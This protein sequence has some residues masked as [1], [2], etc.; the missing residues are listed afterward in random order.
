MKI[1]LVA[2]ARPNFMKVAP[3]VRAI[4]RHNRCLSPGTQRM[5]Y[6]LIHTG[7]H[8]DFEMSA[9]FFRDLDLPTPDIHLNVGSG[10][11]A[12]QTGKIMIEFEKVCL[13]E[14][15]DLVV[16]VGD[17]NS[18]VA[19]ALTAAKLFI[20]V[21]HIEAGLRSF[22]RTM[23]EEINRVLTDQVSDFLFTTFL[24]ANR[25]LIR[26]GIPKKKIFFVG[27]V[28]IDT[29]ISH[30]QYAERSD[31]LEK[32]NLKKNGD[33]V[34]YAVLTL[35]R[36]SNVDDPAVLKGILEAMNRISQKVPVIFPAH[37]RTL[38]RIRKFKLDDMVAFLEKSKSGPFP[39]KLMIVLPLGYLDF[40]CLMSHSSVMLTDS[41]GIQEETTTLGIPCLTL[42]N[43]TERPITVR[44]GTNIMVGNRPDKIVKNAFAVL[45][46]GVQRKKIPMYW[47]GKAAERIIRILTTRLG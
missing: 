44:D 12:E 21:A 38:Q 36:P 15:P 26:E 18:T 7:Q 6:R 11:H 5:R 41:G 42:R 37:P 1:I 46:D 33:V 43:N 28:M 8:Y 3:V 40:L 35:H 31:I 14:K 23:P 17:V 24:D 19:C 10:T 22:D 16:V 20:P 9:S 30:A 29:L 4:Q 45:R 2:G 34:D 27:N 39:K 25:N 47:D 32:F 13:R